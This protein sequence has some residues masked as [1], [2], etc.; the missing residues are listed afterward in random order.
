MNRWSGGVIV[1]IVI[2]VFNVPRLPSGRAATSTSF[3]DASLGFRMEAPDGWESLSKRRFG[4]LR[5]AISQN[6]VTAFTGA[7][8]L[9]ACFVSEDTAGDAP[10]MC[11]VYSR[12]VTR[13]RRNP[14]FVHR[15]SLRGGK[16]G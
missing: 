7:L 4:E 12:E 8:D 2:A 3:A 11:F 9:H 13:E 1:I 16:F 14:R 5:D 6:P 10:A 15:R